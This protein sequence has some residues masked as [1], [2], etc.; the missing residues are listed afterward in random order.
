MP[1]LFAIVIG[2]FVC[3][4]LGLVNY[5]PVKNAEF[6]SIHG[7]E[8][9]KSIIFIPTFELDAILAIAP[10]SLV[11]LIEHVG[12]ITTNSAVVGKN[13]M[14]DP[15]VHRTII[16]R[17]I[18]HFLGQDYLVGPANTTYSE[19]TGVLAVTKTYDPSVIR[20]A[21]CIAILIGL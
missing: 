12:D 5:G 16:R 20:I 7:F 10:I 8:H 3:I 2:Y 9:I 15:G 4:P 19:N 13:F 11:T 17:R 18:G 1:I 14:D 21:A 6:F